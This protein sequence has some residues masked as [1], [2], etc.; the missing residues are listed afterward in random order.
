MTTQTYVDFVENANFVYRIYKNWVKVRNMKSDNFSHNL[1]W[2]RLLSGKTQAEYA[3]QIGVSK[4]AY[5]TY[6]SGRTIPNEYILSKISTISKISIDELLNKNLRESQ[7]NV[8]NPDTK[9]V[10]FT[11]TNSTQVQELKE[12]LIRL[13]AENKLLKE[14]LEK[15]LQ[16]N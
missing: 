2:V 5:Y 8:I 16:K 9:E 15:Q 7:V 4:E 10:D 1:K 13:E 11:L 12:M 14:L 3:R 6:E